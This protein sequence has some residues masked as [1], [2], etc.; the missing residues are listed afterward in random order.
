VRSA[1]ALGDVIVKAIDFDKALSQINALYTPRP[2][3]LHAWPLPQGEMG[4]F[5][6]PINRNGLDYKC[7]VKEPEGG[8]VLADLYL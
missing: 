8:G 6:F 5:S 1:R 3:G 4:E 7:V 2:R